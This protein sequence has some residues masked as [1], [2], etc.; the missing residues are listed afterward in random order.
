M[1]EEGKGTG[2]ISK[3]FNTGI[4]TGTD[5]L[6]EMKVVIEKQGGS[7]DVV[8]VYIGDSDTDLPC[9]LHSDIGII[10]GNGKSVRETCGR[11][12]IKV[13]SGPRLNEIRKRKE[14]DALTLYHF[15]DW[16]GI[17]E[18]GLLDC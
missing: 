2:I 3:A 6:R 15:E 10:I 1:D 17:R 18:S 8:T 7:E 11:V 4:C 9:L 12:G 14:G 16:N 13:E 5:K